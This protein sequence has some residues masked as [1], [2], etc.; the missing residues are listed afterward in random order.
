[1]KPWRP[2]EGWVN[3]YPE[4]ERLMGSARHYVYE[5]GADAMYNAL[6]DEFED[7]WTEQDRLVKLNQ[8]LAER[9]KKV[10]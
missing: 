1:M 8:M 7:C 2:K 10:S 6:L 9:A 5:D 3:P 4:K